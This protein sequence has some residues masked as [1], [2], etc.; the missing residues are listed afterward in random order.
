MGSPLRYFIIYILPLSVWAGYMLGGFY[1]FMTPLFVFGLLPLLDFI[2]G[3]N[4]RNPTPEEDVSLPAETSYRYVTWF[5]VPLQAAMV[6][7]G[8]YVV[9]Q[10]PMTVLELTGFVLSL[11]ISSG[12]LGINVSHELVH[13]IDNRVEPF[14]GRTMLATVAY[15]HWASDHVKG[16]H[17]NVATPVDPAT[18]RLGQSVYAFWR[19]TVT[20]A[21]KSAWEIET[22]FLKRKGKNVWSFSNPLLWCFAAE[23][24]LVI[25]LWYAFGFGAVIFFAVQ[26][27]IAISLL[28]VVNYLEH[29]GMERHLREDGRYEK[30]SPQHSWNSSH[31]MTNYFLFNL[32]RHSDHHASPGR[33]YQ[34]LRHF[35]QAPQLPNG[36]AGMVLLALVPPLW[37]KVMDPKV[38]AHRKSLSEESVQGVKRSV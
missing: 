2:L 8:A 16:H 26:A 33:R 32:Q 27:F 3:L 31:W 1:N 17:R 6:V 34:V 25:A 30:V 22:G 9:T 10:R 18:A 7:W 36:Y 13:R 5:C 24:A 15:M 14:L 19:Q 23:A 4:T 21:W 20:G 35:N 12:A 37:R 29:Y 28:E 11:G 38:D